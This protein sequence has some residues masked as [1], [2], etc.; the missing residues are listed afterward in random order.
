MGF[1]I[2]LLTMTINYAARHV[3]VHGLLREDVMSELLTR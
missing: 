1:H 3:G 2:L